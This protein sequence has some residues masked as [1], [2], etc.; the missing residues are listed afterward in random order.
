MEIERER[1]SP[2]QKARPTGVK[3]S[4][5][6]LHASAGKSDAGDLSW[7]CSPAS[8][9]SYHYL[10]GRDGTVYELVPPERMAYHAGESEWKG[11]K[12][13]N[14]YSIGVSWC[15]RHDGA[16]P[17]TAK[18]IQAGRALLDW[19]AQKYHSVAEIVTH[20]DVAPT[21]KSDPE[22]IPNWHK[23]DWCIVLTR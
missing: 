21:R 9:V 10:I 13:C 2:N 5:I 12:F 4:L 11:R 14:Q 18:Q 7:I 22:K 17:L 6:I 8:R 15:N 23:P 19:L 20:K 1:R 16:E 3:P